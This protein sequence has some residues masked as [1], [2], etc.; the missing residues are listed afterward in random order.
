[1]NNK[2]SLESLQEVW[3]EWINPAYID[4][5]SLVENVSLLKQED[6][7]SVIFKDF[8][9]NEKLE[10]IELALSE[11]KW[12]PLR[13]IKNDEKVQRVSE[14]Y[15]DKAEPGEQFCSHEIISDINKK[16]TPSEHMAEF[17]D[18]LSFINGIGMRSWMA[19]L[20]ETKNLSIKTLEFSRYKRGDFID[21]H[22]DYL[23]ARHF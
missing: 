8:R 1:M 11:A 20:S 10:K 21:W 18:F 12:S 3:S 9:L 15:F 5:S 6:N 14:Q 13:L 22:S 19:V 7:S 17:L 4:P 23:P 2:S 16:G